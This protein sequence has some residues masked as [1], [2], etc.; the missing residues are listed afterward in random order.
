[1]TDEIRNLLKELCKGLVFSVLASFVL[2]SVFMFYEINIRISELEQWREEVWIHI[3]AMEECEPGDWLCEPEF[4]ENDD[5]ESDDGQD[6][7]GVFMEWA[8]KETD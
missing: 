1:L 8:N 7:Y 2:I 5:A 6:Y 4:G 3:P